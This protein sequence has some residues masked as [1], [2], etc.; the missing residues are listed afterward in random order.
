MAGVICLQGGREFTTECREM[1]AEVLRLAG[2]GQVAVL[3]GAARPGSDYAG[4]S[5]RARRHYEALGAHVVVVLDPRDGVDAA[6]D[7]L[8]DDVS[9][10]V[11]PGGSPQSL[12]EVLSGPRC[13]QAGPRS[14]V[15]RLERWCCAREWCSRAVG[16]TPS[17]GSASSTGW[18][19]PTG[20]Q[21]RIAAGRLRKISTCGVCPSAAARSSATEPSVPL[22][23]ANQRVGRTACGGRFR[24]GQT[25]RRHE[26][27]AHIVRNFHMPSPSP[28][29][30]RD[31]E[32]H[33]QCEPDAARAMSRGRA[34]RVRREAP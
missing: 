19:S 24:G 12:R 1:D 20:P 29:C 18:H 34:E 25:R 22:V 8:T 4:A 10:I 32:G 14:R 28:P 26:N 21:A 16:P 5:T 6:L 2:P 23:R 30:C 3:A 15:R 33:S 11:L 17:T 13:T 7:A 9:L 27:L 31:G